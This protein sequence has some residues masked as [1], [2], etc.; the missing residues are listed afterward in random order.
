MRS[1]R[2]PPPAPGPPQLWLSA[3]RLC[4]G[5]VGDAEPEKPCRLIIIIVITI[6]ETM[7]R[8]PASIVSTRL[9]LFRSGSRP[10]AC[11]ALPT[12]PRKMW[13]EW[14]HWPTEL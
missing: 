12:G 7:A 2:P 11:A 4:R 3:V 10:C 13:P 1:E 9:P 6:T 14:A 5:R 8:K